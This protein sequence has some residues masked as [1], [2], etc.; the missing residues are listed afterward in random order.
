[1]KNLY[2]FNIPMKGAEYGVGTYISQLVKSLQTTSIKLNR[3][4]LA[5]PC[6]TFKVETINNVRCFIVPT[7]CC[8]DSNMSNQQYMDI[9]YNDTVYL[10]KSY[11]DN[12]DDNIF[13]VNFLQSG[14]LAEKLKAHFNGKVILTMHYTEWS[15]LLSGNK[16][17]LNQILKKKTSILNIQENYILEIFMSDKNLLNSHFDGIIAI[18]EHSYNDIINLFNVP[19]NKVT[20]INNALSDGYR[21]ISHQTKCQLKQKFFIDEQT[22]VILFAG[23]LDPIKGVNTLIKAFKE[24]LRF[25]PNTDLFIAG[26]GDFDSLFPHSNSYWTK[27]HFTGFLSKSSLHKLYSIADIGVVPSIHEEFGYVAIEMMMHKIPVIVSNTTGLSEIVENGK[28]GLYTELKQNKSSI[29]LSYEDLVRN[30]ISLLSSK[31][32]CQSLGNNGRIRY[33]KNYS[34]ALYTHRMTAFYHSLFGTDDT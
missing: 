10:L 5:A 3:V 15:F 33:L 34:A 30:M 18:S 25:Y 17:L 8:R 24:V 20:L 13:H 7:P 16:R 32:L 31:A 12:G 26:S 27:I 1:M 23:R 29:K 21:H 19:K 9:L 11:I 4:I 14:L 22:N 28:T 2:I 6:T